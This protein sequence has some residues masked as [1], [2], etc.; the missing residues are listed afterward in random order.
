[1]NTDEIRILFEL[2][3][4]KGCKFTALTYRSVDTGELARHT[5]LFGVDYSAAI[6]RDLKYLKRVKNKLSG[7]TL[8]ACEELIQSLE[9]SRTKVSS[10]PEEEDVYESVVPGIK[11]HKQTGVY[12]LYAFAMKKTVVEPATTPRKTVNSKPLTVEKEKLRARLRTSK[13]RQF[14]LDTIARCAVNGGV[15]EIA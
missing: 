1:M 4:T 14:R 10:P 9:K 7:L 13:Y 3:K 6:E 11:H 2:A 8:Q 5:L 15:L 12:Y